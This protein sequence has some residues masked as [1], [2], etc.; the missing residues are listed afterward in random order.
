MLDFLF[1]I[2]ISYS[3]LDCILSDEQIAVKTVLEEDPRK[4]RQVRDVL[5]GAV[6]KLQR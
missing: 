1:N 3:E 5:S 4:Q 6:K 2:L